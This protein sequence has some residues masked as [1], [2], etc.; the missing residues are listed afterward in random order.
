M[1]GSSGVWNQQV[2]TRRRVIDQEEKLKSRDPEAGLLKD[3]E[4]EIFL[5]MLKLLRSSV[6]GERWKY[7]ELLRSSLIFARV[8]V[9]PK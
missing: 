7:K 3:F 2:A 4:D 6:G 5:K 8:V 1:I 9:K